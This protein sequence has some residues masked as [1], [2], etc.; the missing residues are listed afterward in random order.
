[1]LTARELLNTEIIYKML[2]AD[3]GGWE[4]SK[5]N[6]VPVRQGRTKAT[7]LEV[8][9]NPDLVSRQ[10][11]D[12]R[13]TELRQDIQDYAGDD[14]IE[15]WLKLVKWTQEHM[16]GNKAELQRTLE[17]CTKELM[18]F[19]KYK[20]DVRFLRLWIHYADCLSDPADIFAL[21]RENRIGDEYAL[22]YE[23]H[24]AYYELR[25]NTTAAD[26]IY[27]E[28]IKRCAK[29]LDRLK[30]KYMAFQKRMA[31]RI[32]RRI[33]E[34][35]LLGLSTSAG[36]AESAARTSLSLLVPSSLVSSTMNMNSALVNMGAS[37]NRSQQG[38]ARALSQQGN[39]RALS[40]QGN[41]RALNLPGISLPSSSLP[42]LQLPTQQQ[43][44]QLKKPDTAVAVD[45]EFEGSRAIRFP[46]DMS[47]LPSFT[48]GPSVGGGMKGL[49]PF[50]VMRKENSEI[51]ST[52]TSASLPP[53][54][55]ML[56]SMGAAG[57]S[58]I[59]HAGP[60]VLGTAAGSVGSASRLEIC[61][62]DEFQE[63][64]PLAVPQSAPFIHASAAAAAVSSTASGSVHHTLQPV[65]A[66]VP[67]ALGASSLH[68][69][70]LL[71]APAVAPL[72]TAAAT[73]A[74]AAVSDH[75][76]DL[77]DA[78]M[79]AEVSGRY[80][81]SDASLLMNA[82]GSEQSFEEARAHRQSRGHLMYKASAGVMATAKDSSNHS[83]GHA[84][85][86]AL[87][88][89]CLTGA[90]APAS[91]KAGVPASQIGPLFS[92]DTATGAPLQVVSMSSMARRPLSVS[93][94][95]Q[96]PYK[97]Q[98]HTL[99]IDQEL[100]FEGDPSAAHLILP[101]E[102]T[103][104]ISTREAF[105]ALNDMFSD[106]LPHEERRKSKVIGLTSA[107]SRAVSASEIC[108]LANLGKQAVTN[109]LG[110]RP[111]PSQQAMQGSHHGSSNTAG[112]MG[113]HED[114]EFIGGSL[115]QPQQG[116]KE[117]TEMMDQGPSLRGDALQS[118]VSGMYEDTEF[119]PGIGGAN[120]VFDG[121]QSGSGVIRSD[122]HRGAISMTPVHPAQSS[123]SM[124]PSAFMYEDTDFAA[125]DQEW[126]KR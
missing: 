49:K 111:P 14:P 2:A 60:S 108:R 56:S 16:C 85:A 115:N 9:D 106:T 64:E 42:T 57:V 43:Q 1:M 126:R 59:M 46:Q 29:P 123:R 62:D 18:K 4:E 83:K 102:P 47:T 15:P 89:Q 28:G 21:L 80:L 84:L 12:R 48:A 113:I 95:I 25:G 66:A 119:L 35:A 88:P 96:P 55:P 98:Q 51:P 8:L 112:A 114:T 26:D 82:E 75:N 53:Q 99:F 93:T 77:G 101:P 24:G 73:A 40:Q 33:Q 125:L 72:T 70:V 104:T 92:S 110:P 68:H 10:E 74:T 32:Q 19:K 37:I 44:Q 20:S 27:N 76:K 118:S 90:S 100:P 94:T 3:S 52:W 97:S 109:G 86:E 61:V 31:Q 13:K 65:L 17:M 23:A 50:T 105:D 103:V 5:E 67:S 7:L 78:N 122:M 69:K 38:N 124:S 36:N 39:A 117:D 107:A 58:R 30:Q 81:G 54:N 41:A 34:D 22:F 121:T 116:F 120:A 91:H 79:A 45:E 6:F 87:R 71:Q 11:L 63:D